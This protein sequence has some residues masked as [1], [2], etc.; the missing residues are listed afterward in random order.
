MPYLIP[1]RTPLT[2]EQVGRAFDFFLALQ[3]G[4]GG[5]VTGRA[6]ADPELSFVL[7]RLAEDIV[8]PATAV[9]SDCELTADSFALDEVGCI[10][11]SVLR[12]WARDSPATA[13]LGIARSIIRFT[14]NVI[15]D[16]DDAD[17]AGT[18]ETMRDERLAMA[19]AFYGT[20]Q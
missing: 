16:P 15:P 11:L 12:D 10:L 8:L 1:S 20:H 19:A 6:D 7:L 5:N 3:T 13:A 17:T 14:A 9:S 18:L 4:G 2:P